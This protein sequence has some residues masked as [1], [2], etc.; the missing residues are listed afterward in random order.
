MKSMAIGGLVRYF[1]KR[2]LTILALL[3]AVD[4]F[5]DSGGVTAHLD[6]VSTEGTHANLMFKCSI[7][8]DNQTGAT[9]VAANFP[10]RDLALMV[11]DA[12]GHALAKVHAWPMIFWSFY[13][14]KQTFQIHPGSESFQLLYARFQGVGLSLP[15]DTKKVKLQIVGTLS[16]CSYTNC[17]TSNVVDTDVP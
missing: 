17:L 2:L 6:A 1:M 3:I 5:G 11:T 15:P 10:I 14:E 7:T 4:A 8:L 13:S 9:L 16:G 12:D